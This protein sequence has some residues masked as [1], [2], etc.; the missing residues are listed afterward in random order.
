MTSPGEGTQRWTLHVDEGWI[1]M[2]R[3]PD[4]DP[5]GPERFIPGRLRVTL[6]GFRTD[7]S[8]V[9]VELT[10]DEYTRISAAL[11]QARPAQ[12]A[13]AEAAV[14]SLLDSIPASRIGSDTIASR[15]LAA[16]MAPAGF[17]RCGAPRSGW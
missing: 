17:G 11:E 13:S 4:D 2:G 14:R 16:L 15:L 10:Q 3:G 5:L 6:K 7:G 8:E 9:Q 12:P 1:N